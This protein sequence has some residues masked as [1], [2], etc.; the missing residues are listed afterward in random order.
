MVPR[1]NW[2]PGMHVISPEMPPARSESVF[3]A[4]L[5]R[6]R[7]ALRIMRG[8]ETRACE[9]RERLLRRIL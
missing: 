4:Y 3:G 9:T 7:A 5:I 8:Y 2:Y 6:Y 1:L